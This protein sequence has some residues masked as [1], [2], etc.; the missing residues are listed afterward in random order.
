MAAQGFV[1]VVGA[2]VLP[3][4]AAGQVA[5]V[6]RHFVTRGWGIGSGG[7]RGADAYALGAV[8]AGQVYQSLRAD[9]PTLD[10]DLAAGRFA[11]LFA[12]LREHIHAHG[13]RLSTPD[14]I[15]N[16]TG[17]PLAAAAWFPAKFRLRVL[18][19]VWPGVPPG[20]ERYS[21]SQV[22]EVSDGVRLQIQDALYDLLRQRRSVWFG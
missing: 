15:K 6:V 16:A 5:A 22:M 7:A 8:I 4:A 9:C 10:E 13:A 12:W 2:R 1:S 17:K 11:P 20:L 18:P 14:L 3:E 21:R 19:P